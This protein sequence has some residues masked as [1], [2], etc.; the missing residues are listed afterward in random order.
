M[1]D[2]SI[3]KSIEFYGCNEDISLGKFI[4]KR[5][6]TLEELCNTCKRPKYNHSTILYHNNTYILMTV[7]E[8]FVIKE[9]EQ[10]D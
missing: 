10:K 7:D 3:I 8:K 9:E 4:M 2:K 6:N 5:L 1:C